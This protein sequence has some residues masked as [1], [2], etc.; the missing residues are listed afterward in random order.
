[1]GRTVVVRY[2]TREDAAAENRRL[3]GDVFAQL[4]RERPTGLD[5]TAVELSGAAEF[6]H[7]ATTTDAPVLPGLDAF[8]RFQRD[9]GDR[10]VRGPDATEATVLGA[11]RSVGAAVPVAVAFVEAF[12][13]RDLT[14][15]TALLHDDVVFESPRTRLTGA[16]AVAAAIGEFAAAVTGVD[17]VAAYGGDDEAVVCYDMHTGPFGTLRTVDHVTVRGGRVVADT[18]VFDTAQVGR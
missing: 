18:V 12:G 16:G 3:I 14:A 6:V 4:R 10:V 9:I 13:R 11:Y 1:M 17:V 8:G 7:L 5:Y 15:V 2:R